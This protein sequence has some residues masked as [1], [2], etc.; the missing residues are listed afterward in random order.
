MRKLKACEYRES[1]LDFFSQRII[2]EFFQ[3]YRLCIQLIAST[4]PVT[5]CLLPLQ[6]KFQ[7]HRIVTYIAELVQHNTGWSGCSHI[8]IA[9]L[10]L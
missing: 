6:K 3:K 8:G 5:F 1:P 2:T 7:L 9:R 4:D 10:G